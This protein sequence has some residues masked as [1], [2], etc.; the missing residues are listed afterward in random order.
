MALPNLGDLPAL[1]VNEVDEYDYIDLTFGAFNSTN[2][3]RD[4]YWL[5]PGVGEAVQVVSPGSAKG[6][7]PENFTL[8]A[9][10]TRMFETGAVQPGAYP[11]SQLRIHLQNGQAILDWN[12]STNGSGYRVES[13][14]RLTGAAWVLSAEPFLNTWTEAMGTNAQRF[15][16]VFAEP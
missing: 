13:A 14:S 1:R 4:Y 5:V 2:Y 3:F 12:A 9:T 15:Y 16:R 8:A 10:M 7:P 11:V 6:A